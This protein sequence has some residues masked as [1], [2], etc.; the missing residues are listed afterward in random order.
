MENKITTAEAARILGV[1]PTRVL[2]LDEEL[3]PERIGERG[4]RV[5][6]RARVVAHAEARAGTRDARRSKKHVRVR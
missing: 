5:F 3:Q 1:T 6:E 2:Q 4:V